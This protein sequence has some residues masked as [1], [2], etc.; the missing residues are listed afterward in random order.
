MRF[1][2]SSFSFNEQ[3]ARGAM[4]I[5]DV[6]EWIA[7]SGGEHLELASDSFSPEGADII[8]NFDDEPDLVELIRRAALSQGVSLSGMCIPAD[9]TGESVGERESQVERVKRNIRVCDRLGIQHIRHDVTHWTRRRGDVMEF[10]QVLPQIADG[11]RRIAQFAAKYGITTSV[12]NHGYFMNGSEHIQ[13]LIAEVNELNFRMTLDVGNFLCVDENPFIAT[14][15]NL[16]FASFVHF[17]DYYVRRYDAFPGA[18]WYRTLGGNYLRSAII[19][20]GDMDTR[21]ILG[22]LVDARYDGYISIEFEGIEDC[23]FGCA[24]GLHNQGA[25]KVAS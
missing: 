24:T 9:L 1:G 5:A 13:R 2:F 3:M 6:I 22:T 20:F 17:K 4:S 23:S 15:S 19:G 14:R 12:E 16:P 25:G 11:S 10:E 7:N 8:W 18:G 21:G